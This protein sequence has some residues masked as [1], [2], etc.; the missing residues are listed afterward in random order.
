MRED[1]LGSSLR[2]GHTA[3]SGPLPPIIIFLW[4]GKGGIACTNTSSGMHNK[5]RVVGGRLGRGDNEA[6]SLQ[7]SSS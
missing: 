3:V 2:Q 6:A 4:G 1:N 5:R 7:P